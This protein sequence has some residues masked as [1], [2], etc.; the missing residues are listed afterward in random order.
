MSDAA[1]HLFG[2]TGAAAVRRRGSQEACL[3][4]MLIAVAEL[5]TSGELSITRIAEIISGGTH[6]RDGLSTACREFSVGPLFSE[7]IHSARRTIDETVDRI[8]SGLPRDGSELLK[9]A[10]ADFARHYTMQ[11]ERDV[12]E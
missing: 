10:L 8:Q 1:S 11:S 2:Q 3:S 12:H 4:G 5:H 9:P 6:L 7:G